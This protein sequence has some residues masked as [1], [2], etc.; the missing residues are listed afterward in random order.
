M[1][2]DAHGDILTDVAINL[3]KGVDIFNDYHLPKYK[4]G[5]VTASVFVNFTN[6]DGENQRKDF[7]QITELALPYFKNHDEVQV[8]LEAS[9]L[10]D[11]R[12][13]VIFGIEGLKA[14]NDPSEVHTLYEQGYRHLGIAWNE[15]NQFAGGTYADGGLS[16]MGEEIIKIAEDKKMIIDVAH[17][18]KKSFYDVARV[19][20]KPIFVS[21]AAVQGVRMHPRNLSDDQLMVLKE[22]DGVIGIPALNFFLNDDEQKATVGDII[23]HIMHVVNTVGARHVGFG[24]DFCYYLGEDKQNPL[25]GMRHISDVDKIPALLKEA[26]LSD[27]EI[28]LVCYDNMLR[29]IKAHLT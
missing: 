24:F 22:T 28:K 21:H 10:D 4:Q 29:V 3:D 26:G 6:P 23:K 18:N 25:P 16:P 1:F 17:L 14:V 15:Q 12:L 20:N 19:S 11:P 8:V 7:D 5:Q 9:D 2:F 27:E 13:K